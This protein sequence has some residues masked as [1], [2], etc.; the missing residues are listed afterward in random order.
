[1]RRN[2]T[3]ELLKKKPGYEVVYLLLRGPQRRQDLADHIDAD[4]GTLARWLDAASNEG[5]VTISADLRTSPQTHVAEK[6]V[7]VT[8]N[9]TIPDDLIP[10]I[11][12]RGSRGFRTSVP[13]FTDTGVIHRWNDPH[14][15][16]IE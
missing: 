2:D 15:L 11:E 7:E 10:V 6:Y 14:S 5:L 9:R 3:I 16:E 4:G 1:M 8:L 13:E 12:S